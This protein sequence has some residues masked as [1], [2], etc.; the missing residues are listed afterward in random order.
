M[1]E[2]RLILGPVLRHVDETSATVWVE[3]DRPCVVEILASTSRTFQVG[4]HH[5]GLVVITGLTP[6]ESRPYT[7]SLD[8]M[9]GEEED[10]A[11]TDD[12]DGLRIRIGDDA[13]DL[14]DD[15]A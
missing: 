2:P 5:Y 7:V 12:A 11:I 4:G 1:A 14:I 10:G 15:A 13:Y 9:L 8:S 6:G 3:T